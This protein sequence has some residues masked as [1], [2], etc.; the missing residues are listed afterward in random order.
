[1]HG[2]LSWKAIWQQHAGPRVAGYLAFLL[3][4]SPL[5][6][7]PLWRTATSSKG[8][9]GRSRERAASTHKAAGA[10]AGGVNR[11]GFRAKPRE[12][13]RPSAPPLGR[14]FGWVQANAG[15]DHAN[16][17]FEHDCTWRRQEQQSGELQGQVM[18]GNGLAVSC[19]CCHGGRHVLF[20]GR[21]IIRFRG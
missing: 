14:R 1:M 17:E 11:G 9:Q 8:G 13:S 4:A 21:L 20:K 16:G 3:F 5:L 18:A 2:A 6:L 15:M 10:G 12:C 19:G 7:L